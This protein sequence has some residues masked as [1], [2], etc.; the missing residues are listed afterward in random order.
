MLIR[1]IMESG[2][3]EIKIMYDEKR[4]R[5]NTASIETLDTDAERRIKLKELFDVFSKNRTYMRLLDAG[6]PKCGIIVIV[7]SIIIGIVSL[8]LAL[9]DQNEVSPINSASG[10]VSALNLSDILA[11]DG[12]NS[13]EL[14][15]DPNIKMLLTIFY[16]QAVVQN[17]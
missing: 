14:I 16:L 15:I 13:Y 17:Q 9:S 11:R 6:S 3:R 8:A 2:N 5:F 12:S 7:L 10:L 1:I 4:Y